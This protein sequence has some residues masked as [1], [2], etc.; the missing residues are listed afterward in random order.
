[1]TDI[2]EIIGRSVGAKDVNDFYVNNLLNYRYGTRRYGWGDNGT[3]TNFRELR[4]YIRDSGFR[5]AHGLHKP[6][7]VSF[8]SDVDTACIMYKQKEDAFEIQIG[9]VFLTPEFYQECAKAAGLPYIE[10][11]AIIVA[12]AIVNYMVYHETLHQRYTDLSS[13]INFG[14]FIIDMTDRKYHNELFQQILNYLEDLFIEHRVLK[15]EREW[16]S[17]L[18]G[19]WQKFFF[20]LESLELQEDEQF[21]VQKYMEYARGWFG[22]NKPQLLGNT[23]EPAMAVIDYIQNHTHLFTDTFDRVYMAMDIYDFFEESEEPNIQQQMQQAAESIDD[24]EKGVEQS[25]REIVNGGNS[26]N[27]EERS[28]MSKELEE[29]ANQIKQAAANGDEAAKQIINAADNVLRELRDIKQMEETRTPFDYSGY[30]PPQ[31]YNDGTIKYYDVLEIGK[32]IDFTPVEKTNWL[33]AFK[34]E[35]KQFMVKAPDEK[36]VSRRGRLDA[37]RLYMH[38]FAGSILRTQKVERDDK[39]EPNVIVLMD[40]SGSTS[41]RAVNAD[42]NWRDDE[43]TIFNFITTGGY[44]IHKSLSSVGISHSI[45]AH[46]VGRGAGAEIIGVAAFENVL[47]PVSKKIVTTPTSSA[48]VRFSYLNAVYMG[49]NADGA[50]LDFVTEAAIDKSKENLIIVV[51]D[52]APTET[53]GK[54]KMSPEE[55]LV[56]IINK[57]RTDGHYVVAMTVVNNKEVIQANDRIYGAANNIVAYDNRTFIQ[58]VRRVIDN[59]LDNK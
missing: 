27:S 17:G 47:N 35:I 34:N 44:F 56:S 25:S 22:V 10:S 9:T 39:G 4:T 5:Y 18:I 46:T 3:P 12:L 48:E 19:D 36:V 57:L 31:Y 29:L 7:H 21:T 58:S 42:G 1:M 15:V 28:G 11:N 53:V 41:G 45:Y 2:L 55:H 38:R 54:T 49:G 14:K 6:L 33:D 20:S 51:S 59:L 32:T 23:P 24:Y 37:S 30:T 13:M 8:R 40:V 43:A 50:A 52:G 26:S 16:L